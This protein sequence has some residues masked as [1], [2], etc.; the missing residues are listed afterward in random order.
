MPDRLKPE[1]SRLHEVPFDY[2]SIE[3][4]ALVSIVLGEPASAY[5]PGEGSEFTVEQILH[6]GENILAILCRDAIEAAYEAAED[7]RTKLDLAEIARVQKENDC[8]DD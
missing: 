5:S 8:D 7:A 3:L 6:E 1:A 2:H 4:V